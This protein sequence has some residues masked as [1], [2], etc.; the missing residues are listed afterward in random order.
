MSDQTNTVEHDPAHAGEPVPFA[1]EHAADRELLEYAARQTYYNAVTL[2]AIAA[3]LA[4]ISGRVRQ[5]ETFLDAVRGHPLVASAL[6]GA[7]AAP[8]AGG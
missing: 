8:L 6:K 5:L 7:G 3:E 1:I 2:D 4:S